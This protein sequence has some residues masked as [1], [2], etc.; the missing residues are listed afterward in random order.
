MRVDVILVSYNQEN[1]IAQA[2]ESILMQ[3]VRDDVV[4]RII[5]VDNCSTDNT[6]NIIKS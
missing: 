2:V 6:L 5:V 1:Y 3:Q 4:V